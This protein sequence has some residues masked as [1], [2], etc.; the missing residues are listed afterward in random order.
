M[1]LQPTVAGFG[2]IGLDW[3]AHPSGGHFTRVGGTCGNVLCVM[4]LFGWRSV[5]VSRLNGAQPA[6]R[7]IEEL[8]REQGVDCRWL[9]QKPTEDV[10]GILCQVDRR[11]RSHRFDNSCPSCASQYPR[12]PKWGADM[13]D[14]ATSAIAEIRP[15]A[16]V[17]DRKV[18][19]GVATQTSN[20]VDVVRRSREECL[21]AILPQRFNGGD[22]WNEFAPHASVMCVSS[23]QV[24]IDDIEGAAPPARGTRLEV[25]TLG[26]RGLVWRRRRSG[27]HSPAKWIS[28]D[29]ALVREVVDATGAGDW[30]AGALLA[31]M[32]NHSFIECVDD[33]TI[34]KAL[35]VAMNAATY[36]CLFG[37]ARG[38]SELG[39]LP[40]SNDLV[41][42][43]AT[44]TQE[45]TFGASVPKSWPEPEAP[46]PCPRC[47]TV[48]PLL[49]AS[50][51][52]TEPTRELV[53]IA[54]SRGRI[55]SLKASL[56]ALSTLA[57]MLSDYCA[58]KDEEI[59]VP[60]PG[61]ISNVLC[62]EAYGDRTRDILVADY[63]DVKHNLLS[64][65]ERPKVTMRVENGGENVQSVLVVDD[66][67]ATGN[68][69][70]AAAKAILSQW[71]HVRV[72]F[73]VVASDLD[74]D[75]VPIDDDESTAQA[76]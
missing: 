27:E 22:S 12:A 32:K 3:V 54:K 11:S 38:S 5:P 28:Q 31:Q 23:E 49:A 75:E 14:V 59:A 6:G 19:G 16:V 76:S 48:I 71:P 25:C 34:A 21:V 35:R 33:G 66:V 10:P 51:Y 55:V 36:A 56:H 72:R 61:S 53:Q 70:R 2:N 15:D 29:A 18:G 24:S 69:L 9:K 58:L 1:A 50:R 73:A 64:K 13:V 40:K 60:V 43:F 46:M 68:H 45:G 52:Y 57:R 63:G 8:L 20:F 17:L 39:A 62:R 42:H 37:G 44:M 65:E 47:P 30:L 41:A 26:A 4:A 74:V 67:A 7:R